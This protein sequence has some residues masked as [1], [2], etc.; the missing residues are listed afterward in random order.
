MY[1]DAFRTSSL[2]S[3]VSNVISPY[4]MGFEQEFGYQIIIT[5]QRLTILAVSRVISP[6]TALVIATDK[7][8][9][10]HNIL[11]IS[12]LKHMLWVLIGSASARRFQ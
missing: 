6:C 7:R 12:L 9:Y 2:I 1:F 11:F 4:N 8:G 3:N 5:T 10:P